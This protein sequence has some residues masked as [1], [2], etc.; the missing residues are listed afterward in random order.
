MIKVTLSHSDI[1][2]GVALQWWS[3]VT[4]SCSKVIFPAARWYCSATKWYYY[5]AKS[6]CPAVVKVMFPC[7]NDQGHIVLQQGHIVLQQGDI[8]LQQG[9]IVLH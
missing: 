3:K 2:G 6:H 1:Q 5:V 4:L 9:D 7:S 8:V